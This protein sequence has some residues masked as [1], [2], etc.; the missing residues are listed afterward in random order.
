M[1]G[2]IIL[3]SSSPRRYEL[4]QKITPDFEVKVSGCDETI[5]DNTLPGD[6]VSLLSERKAR[7]VAAELDTDDYIIIASDT[8]VAL[9]DMILGKPEDYNS[10]YNMLSKLS[11][12]T[13]HV[14][15]GVCILTNNS[16]DVFYERTAVTFN[17]LSDAEIRSYIESGEPMDKAGAY[18]IQGI[19][20]KFITSINGDYYNVVGLPLSSLYTHIKDLL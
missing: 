13:H 1:A 4:L 20:G 18:G 5:P 14:Y 6:A 15:S 2:R 3:A 11:G 16:C 17:T 19:A 12:R 9:D 7:A 8:V 10:A